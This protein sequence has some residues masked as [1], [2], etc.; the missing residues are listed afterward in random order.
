M[1]LSPNGQTNNEEHALG[2]DETIR[3]SSTGL[4]LEH[5]VHVHRELARAW[6]KSSQDGRRMNNPRE[7]PEKKRACKFRASSGQENGRKDFV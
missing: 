1:T 3:E 4:M 2:N 5:T 6:V 7:S